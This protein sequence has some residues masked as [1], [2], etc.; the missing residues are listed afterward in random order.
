MVEGL[1]VTASSQCAYRIH[2]HIADGAGKTAR[3]FGAK[4]GDHQKRAFRHVGGGER[5]TKIFLDDRRVVFHEIDKTKRQA[6]NQKIQCG[7]AGI[8]GFALQ[9]GVDCS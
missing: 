2:H 5:L 9:C 6:V 4:K 1:Q 8:F 3:G 7:Q